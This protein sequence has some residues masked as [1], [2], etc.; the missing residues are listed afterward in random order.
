MARMIPAMTMQTAIATAIVIF[1]TV[2]IPILCLSP[3]LVGDPVGAPVTGPIV[4]IDAPGEAG[5]DAESVVNGGSVGIS[6]VLDGS[7]ARVA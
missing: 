2:L 4:A 3:I 1:S 6:A 7:G 5:V